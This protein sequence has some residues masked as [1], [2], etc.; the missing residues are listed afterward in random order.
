[1]IQP[2]EVK[3]I[4]GFFVFVSLLTGLGCVTGIIVTWIKRKDR[5]AVA[6]PELANRLSE[7]SDRLARLDSSIDTIAVEV[8][9]ISEAQRFTAR[10]LAERPSTGRLQEG[11]RP[12]GTATPH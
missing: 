9:R 4:E 8:E 12:P 11:V 10:V 7:I 5:K 6:S 3:L 2:V 1:M